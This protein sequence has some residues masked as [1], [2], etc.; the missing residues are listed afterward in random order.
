MGT[1]DIE[2]GLMKDNSL[3]AKIY[4]LALKRNISQTELS[5]IIYGKETVQ[6]SN[7]NKAIQ[8]LLEKNYI[9]EIFFTNKE[10]EELGINK[11]SKMYKSTYK[12]ILEYIESSVRERKETSPSLHKE[13]LTDQDKQVLD[14]IFN[15][16][17]FSK[18]YKE[19]FLI[20]QKGEV[21]RAENKE[22]YSHCPI[23]FFAFFL[24][25]FFVISRLLKGI[26]NQ[27]VTNEEIINTHSFDRFLEENKNKITD[28]ELKEIKKVNSIAV[29]S[30]GHYDK[31]KTDF[32]YYTEDIGI[33]LIPK[34]LAEKLQ[35]IGRVPLT[36][37]IH[38][39]LA[40]K[41]AKRKN[42]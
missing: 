4:F 33:L 12:P 32:D 5:K 27:N 38:F 34:S 6:L 16:K 15:S 19:E 11:I 20:T 35:S 21:R 36:V 25:E 40:I 31:E 28:E 42:K 41:S 30:L 22:I 26:V 9:K 37:A 10:K 8:K 39:E 24:E 7:I 23:R 18:F 2:E 13:E 17:W 14:L 1:Y 29:K 3:S